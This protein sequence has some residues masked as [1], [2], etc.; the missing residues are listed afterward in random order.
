MFTSILFFGLAI[1]T[2]HTLTRLLPTAWLV[3]D[4]LLI[5]FVLGTARRLPGLWMA[6]L[7]A[8]GVMGLLAVRHSMAVFLIYWLIG[9]GIAWTMRR[10]DGM[11]VS[12]QQILLGSGELMLVIGWWMLDGLAPLWWLIGLG[13]FRVL[14]TC[15]VGWITRP[16]LRPAW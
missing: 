5:A 16:L 9:E 3:P 15:A 1:F 14:I 4:M 13:L 6:R 7:L 10:W 12:V 8:S 11:H 2:S